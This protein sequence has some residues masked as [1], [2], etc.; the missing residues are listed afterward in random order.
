MHQ[1]KAPLTPLEKVY[2]EIALLKK[3]EHPNVVRLVEGLM[4][5]SSHFMLKSA[6]V[7]SDRGLNSLIIIKHY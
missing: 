5:V 3:L 7:E 1:I 2:R 6:I 4:D